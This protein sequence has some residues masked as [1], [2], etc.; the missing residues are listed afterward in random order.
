MKTKKEK[1]NMTRSIE[2]VSA[3]GRT[4]SIVFAITYLPLVGII[5]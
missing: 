3:D 4:Y 5:Y 2:V 1:K